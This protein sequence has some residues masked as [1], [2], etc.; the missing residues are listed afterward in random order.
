MAYRHKQLG[1][2]LI[3]IFLISFLL[4]VDLLTLS[5]IFWQHIMPAY[6]NPLLIAA[7]VFVIAAAVL[8]STFSVAIEDDHLIWHFTFGFWRRRAA[9]SEISSCEP[10]KNKWWHGWGIRKIPGGWLY[11]V[12]GFQA[13]EVRLENGR[14]FRLGS[15]EAK[16]LAAAINSAQ[17]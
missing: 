9:L 5:I 1:F 11:N 8:F 7:I 16:K 13:V 4:L 15:D 6:A 10:V 2:I 3:S 17:R 12:S 14:M